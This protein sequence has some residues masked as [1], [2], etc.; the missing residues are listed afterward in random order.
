M[1]LKEHNWPN[2]APLNDLNKRNEENNWW[3]Q[4]YGEDHQYIYML[5]CDVGNMG[6]L[7]GHIVPLPGHMGTLPGHMG[8]LPGQMGILPYGESPLGTLPGHMGA[9]SGHMGTLSGHMGPTTYQVIWVWYGRAISVLRGLVQFGTIKPK[10]CMDWI[11]WMGYLWPDHLDYYIDQ[12]TVIKMTQ[13]CSDKFYLWKFQERFQV[14]WLQG[15]FSFFFAF[16]EFHQSD[17]TDTNYKCRYKY[18]YIYRYKYRY[19]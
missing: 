2:I 16:P 1:W 15:L 12:L 7:P 13:W 8:T 5:Q 14:P 11:G 3:D 6:T 10:C 19:K 17:H 18:R 4:S 9:L